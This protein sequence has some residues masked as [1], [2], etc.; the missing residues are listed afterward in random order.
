M[1]IYIFFSL[2]NSNVLCFVLCYPSKHPYTG[3]YKYLQALGENGLNEDYLVGL[4]NQC[5]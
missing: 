2:L 3:I 1:Y 4:K 5:S